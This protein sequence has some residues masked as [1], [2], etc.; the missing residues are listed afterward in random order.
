MAH[1]VLYLLLN[2]RG[3]IKCRNHTHVETKDIFT[4][5]MRLNLSYYETDKT[6]LDW[7]NF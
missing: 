2:R 5:Q 6:A 1:I 7:S 4:G 3:R